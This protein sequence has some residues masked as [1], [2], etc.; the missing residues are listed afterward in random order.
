MCRMSIVFSIV[1]YACCVSRMCCA[2]VE[3]VLFDLI[4]CVCSLL[5]GS[6]V[7]L[8]LSYI[9]ELATDFISLQPTPGVGK[10]N[11]IMVPEVCKSMTSH[12]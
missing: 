11:G 4:A 7:P 5:S 3:F 12:Y 8:R 6:E 1:P 10:G 2:Y 9:F